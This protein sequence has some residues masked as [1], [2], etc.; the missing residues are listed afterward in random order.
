M[1]FA[2]VY[3]WGH[4]YLFVDSHLL[5]NLNFSICVIWAWVVR[6]CFYEVVR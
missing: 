2:L 1:Q 6:L 3:M 4:F 5:D